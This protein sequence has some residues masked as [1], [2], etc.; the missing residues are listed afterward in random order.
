ML[1]ADG[2]LRILVGGAVEELA[3]GEGARLDTGR[4]KKTTYRLVPEAGA[5]KVTHTHRGKER[6]HHEI[7]KM[8][9]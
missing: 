2:V 1:P 6:M 3:V 7:I 5:V 9:S 4:P 8:I